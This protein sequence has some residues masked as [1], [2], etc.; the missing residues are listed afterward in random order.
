MALDNGKL[1]VKV[2]IVPKILIIITMMGIKNDVNDGLTS[3]NELFVEITGERL[4]IAKK[5]WENRLGIVNQWN[6]FF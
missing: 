4:E 3:G 1:L 6:I 2:L 5:N